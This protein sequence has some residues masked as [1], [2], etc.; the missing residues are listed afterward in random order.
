MPR[1]GRAAAVV[2]TAAALLTGLLPAVAGASA[3]GGVASRPQY[4][5]IPNG[6]TYYDTNG[7]PIEAHGGG[8]LKR[9]DTYY[10]VGEDKSQGSARFNGLNLYKSKDLENWQKVRQILTVDSEDTRGNKILTHAKVERPK[11]L[12]N[13]KTKKYVLWGHWEM[14]ADYSASEVLVA[15]SST[16]DG[17]YTITSK[18]HFRPGAGNTEAE[19]MGDRVGQPTEDFDTSAKDAANKKHAYK[20]VQADYPA[21]ILQYKAPDARA[22]EKLSYVGDD[23]YG[24]SQAGNSWTY[25]LNDITHD[26]TVKAKAVRMTGFDTSAYDRYAKDYNVSTSGYIV[27]YPTEN[28]SGMMTARYTIGDP[29][30]SHDQLVAP[31]VSPTLK[32]SSDPSVVLVNSQDVAFVTSATADAISYFT[33]DGSDPADPDNPQ[34]RR[35]QDGTRIPLAGAPGKRTVVKAVTEKDGKASEVTSVTYQVAEAASDVPVFTPVINRVPGTYGTFGYKE[36]RILSPSYGAETYYTMDGQDPAPARKGDNIGYGSRD[37]T[38]HQDEKTGEAYLVTAQDHIYMRVW[39][40]NDSFT[41]VVPDKEYDMYVGEHR[42]APA[43]V[44]NGGKNGRYVYLMTS[45]QSGWYPN[46]AQYGRTEDLDAGFGEPRDAYGYRNGQKAWS[47]LQLVGDNTTYGSQPTKILNIGT[48]RKPS[49]VYI[50]D[51]WRP[52]LLLKSTYVAMP[53]TISDSG[54]GGKGLMRLQP[55]P[56]LDLDAKNGKVKQPDWKLLSLNKPVTA[57]PKVRAAVGAPTESLSDWETTPEQEATGIY[58]HYDATEANDGK[59][60]DVSVYDDTEQYYKSAGLPFSWQ[61][62]L[63][64]RHK[65]AWIGLSFKT[66]GGSDNVHRYTVSGSTD[67]QRWTELVDNTQNNRVGHQSHELTGSYRYVKLDVYKSFD[68]AHGKDADWSRGLYE[69][70]VY[71]K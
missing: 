29:G 38:V 26:T 24:T 49:Y 27:R 61:V 19:A 51:R 52:D 46:Q 8:F 40:L 15:T 67:G 70:S 14:A 43:L 2:V 42:E 57:S 62:D 36:L 35:Y 44:R 7:D 39:K 32:E 11:L 3:S 18:G 23:D 48:D 58:R 31:V 21:K 13:E 59:D 50:G 1:P 64:G 33:T 28:A 4:D 45:Y 9:G 47:S 30:T 69:V 5:A 37:F 34:R 54:N 55:T 17:P 6:Q 16:I 25:Q 53:L 60:G 22:P 41:D 65:L 66:V 71:G 63:G 20:P 10:W 12:Y 56:R 68:L